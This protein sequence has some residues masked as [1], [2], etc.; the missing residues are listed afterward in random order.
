MHRVCK[1]TRLQS[2]VSLEAHFRNQDCQAPDTNAAKRSSHLQCR[3]TEKR[4]ADPMRRGYRQLQNHWQQRFP[5]DHLRITP[6][7][8]RSPGIPAGYREAIE[9]VRLY[10]VRAIRASQSLPVLTLLFFCVVRHGTCCHSFFPRHKSGGR[11]Q[12]NQQ[13]CIQTSLVQ[14]NG[15]L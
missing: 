6:W 5:R 7:T 10:A 12:V 15:K 13:L 8:I 3:G 14:R 2:E 1:Q 11:F 4:H 9:H